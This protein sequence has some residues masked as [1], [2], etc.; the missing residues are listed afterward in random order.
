MRKVLQGTRRTIHSRE[1]FPHWLQKN[2]IYGQRPMDEE[3]LYRKSDPV[4]SL[5]WKFTQSFPFMEWRWKLDRS[6][7]NMLPLYSFEIRSVTVWLPVLMMEFWNTK[8]I[9]ANLP[10]TCC[11]KYFSSYH[12]ICCRQRFR[13]SIFLPW[14]SMR[15]QLELI[16]TLAA[17]A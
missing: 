9:M 10:E 16:V 15:N 4:E 14:H 1:S 5:C 11:M 2:I 12:C 3:E 17:Y 6:Y 7:H 8:Q 13:S